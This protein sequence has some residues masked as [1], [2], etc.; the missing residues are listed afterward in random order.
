MQRRWA[1]ELKAKKWGLKAI[2]RIYIRSRYKREPLEEEIASIVLD[3][4]E[5]NRVLN[6]VTVEDV[7]EAFK[8]GDEVRI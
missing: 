3:R 1:K 4:G 8:H 2:S 6:A 7:M 5:T